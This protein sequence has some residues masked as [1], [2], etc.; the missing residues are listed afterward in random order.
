MIKPYPLCKG[1]KFKRA[2]LKK[3]IKPISCRKNAVICNINLNEKNKIRFITQLFRWFRKDSRFYELNFSIKKNEHI[4]NLDFLNLSVKVQKAGWKKLL[5]K[6][7]YHLKDYD[8][9]KRRS[10]SLNFF[11]LFLNIENSKNK[12]VMIDLVTNKFDNFNIFII[13]NSYYIEEFH[14]IIDTYYKN[15]KDEEELD[16]IFKDLTYIFSWNRYYKVVGYEVYLPWYY[17]KEEFYKNKKRQSEL[18]HKCIIKELTFEEIFPLKKVKGTL[19]LEDIQNTDDIPNNESVYLNI[20]EKKYN[21]KE[22]LIKEF[23]K[24]IFFFNNKQ[25]TSYKPVYFCLEYIEEDKK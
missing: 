22:D 18:N 20:K 19:V 6:L 16:F 21:K 15:K 1:R 23:R 12:E 8:K 25:K 14:N 17:I 2:K 3:L 13:T 10:Y 7:D 11:F 9:L 5:L 24:L 4:S